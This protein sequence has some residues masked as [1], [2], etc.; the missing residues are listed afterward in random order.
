MLQAGA[1]RGAV[2]SGRGGTRFRV[3]PQPP[4]TCPSQAPETIEISAPAGSILSGPADDRMYFVRPLGKRYPYGVNIGPLGTP[5]FFAPPWLGPSAP[6]VQPGPGGHFDHLQV[7]TP[8]FEAAHLFGVAR[9]VMD[10]WEAHLGH[11]IRWHFERDFDRLELS[12]LPTWDN[13]QIGYGYLEVG[14]HISASGDFL[15]FALNFDVIAHEIGHEIIYSEVGLPALDKESGEYFGFHEAAAD[16]VAL[17]AALHFPS[18]VDRLLEISRGNIYT[19]NEFNRF[20]EFSQNEEIRTASN[21]LKLSDFALGWTD[22]HELSQALSGALFDIFVDIFHQTLVSLGVISKD[23]KELSD[24]TEHAPHQIPEL[25][26][27]FDRAYSSD[28]SGFVY[29]LEET[30]ELFGDMLAAAW[31]NL[32]PDNL[33][34]AGFADALIDAGVALSGEWLRD[35]L[36]TNFWWRDIGIV[37]AGPR[38]RPPGRGSHSFSARS[39]LPEHQATFRRMSYRERHLLGTALASGLW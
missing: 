15:P 13:G 4:F 22:E 12:I 34:Y 16:W 14:G 29:A 28:R 19:Y 3:F 7:G 1:M 8:E 5:W 2:R 25:Q 9:F 31:A 32:S 36:L 37:E 6:P 26:A 35:I 10:I 20:S 27:K 38:L 11:P 24:I 17:I 33:S 21:F 18:V 39:A 23:L 30:R